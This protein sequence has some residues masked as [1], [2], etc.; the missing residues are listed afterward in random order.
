MYKLIDLSHSINK[1]TPVHPG[2]EPLELAKI[3]DLA[4]DGFNN[5][6]LSMNMHAGTHIDGPMHMTGGGKYFDELHI[7]QFI[8]NGCL[9]DV[10]GEDIVERKP[11]YEKVI[12]NGDIILLYTGWS[13][14]YGRTDYYNGYP[15]I[16]AGLAQ[17]FIDKKVKMICLDSPS[18]DHQP[19]EIHKM[20][21]K[22]DVLIA[23]NLTNIDKLI[24]AKSFEIL[25]LPIKMHADSA[26]ARIIAWI[27]E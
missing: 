17:L 23:E 19:Y 25:A 12:K 16:S 15:S 1:D 2:D 7:E 24:S 18:P 20:L 4:S 9:L 11:K 27:P 21:L 6:Y 13:T 8:G 26:P 14:K 22:N 5:Y 10:S 3:N